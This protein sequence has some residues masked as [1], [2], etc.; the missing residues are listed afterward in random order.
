MSKDKEPTI[1]EKK[2]LVNEVAEFA[3]GKYSKKFIDLEGEKVARIWDFAHDTTGD[4]QERAKTEDD[5][6]KL[7]LERCSDAQRD[8][9]DTKH[10]YGGQRYAGAVTMLQQSVEKLCKAYGFAFGFIDKSD[11]KSHGV[12]HKS[13]RVFLFGVKNPLMNNFLDVMK[14]FNPT[15]NTD[16]SGLD[17]TIN[18]KTDELAN[19][20]AEAIKRFVKLP[21]DI[22]ENMKQQGSL[23]VVAKGILSMQGSDE[24]DIEA[25][26]KI[27]EL[28][29]G[30][31]TS[32]LHM[33]LLS[34]VTYCHFGKTRYSEGQDISEVYKPGL[35]I[36]DAM[37]DVF[38]AIQEAINN[39]KKFIEIRDAT[40]DTVQKE[41][42]S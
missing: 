10:L 3:L 40:K 38:P 28:F 39:L 24:E 5:R 15:L 34:A 32:F 33:Y 12:G 1:D 20:S 31:F 23:R 35:G 6:G 29:A 9:D 13:P 27:E 26:K 8:L 41:P 2:E 16:I 7:A 42:V 4:L 22:T 14:L 37:E 30:V 19:A 21:K 11:E 18:N 17:N 25:Q 36:V